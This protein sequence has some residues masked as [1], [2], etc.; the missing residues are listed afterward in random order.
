MNKSIE[1]LA[2]RFGN[3]KVKDKMVKALLSTVEK[4]IVPV[5]TKDGQFKI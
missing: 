2:K 5:S 3:K 1:K 4:N